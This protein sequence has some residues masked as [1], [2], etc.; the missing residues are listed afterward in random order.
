[1]FNACLRENTFPKEWKVAK[2]VLI[3]KGDKPLDSPKSYRPI[4]L[5]NTI[6]KFLESIIKTR[7]ENHLESSHGLDTKQF[8]F[9][10]G[11]STIDAIQEVIRTVDKASSGPLYSRKLC[12][13]VALDVAN[14]FNTA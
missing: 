2:L 9:R 6:G 14:A 3:R 12:A 4:C 13:V 11:H 1:M 5:L 10:K 7:I 8:G